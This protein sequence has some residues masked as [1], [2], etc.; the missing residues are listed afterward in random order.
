M[1]I[2]II[3]THIITYIYPIVGMQVC[4]YGYNVFIPARKKPVG[5]RIKSTSVPT[6]IN[7][8]QTP[9]PIWFLLAGTLVKCVRCHP[10][11]LGKGAP[12]GGLVGFRSLRLFRDP[13]L[14]E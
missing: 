5:L 13:A 9:H 12:K 7:S 14:V 6:N 1:Y 11:F 4:G 2:Y 10:Y 8:H 3:H